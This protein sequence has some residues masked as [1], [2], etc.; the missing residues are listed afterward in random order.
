M[1]ADVAVGGAVKG[2]LLLSQPAAADL[3]FALRA[4]AIGVS[5]GFCDDRDPCGVSFPG[6][7]EVPGGSWSVAFAVS[8]DVGRC[9]ASSGVVRLRAT[10]TDGI[11]LVSNPIRLRALARL[12]LGEDLGLIRG[13][14]YED[15]KHRQPAVALNGPGYTLTGPCQ[16]GRPPGAPQ[17]RGVCSLWQL[18]ACKPP[19]HDWDGCFKVPA[20]LTGPVYAVTVTYGLCY[21]VDCR[22]LVPTQK[23]VGYYEI[24]TCQ[25]TNANATFTVPS[26]T[27]A[28]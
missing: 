11:E 23:V 20:T 7:I 2:L 16:P 10:G 24:L 15:K 6:E 13:D 5:T 22:A 26:C 8:F 28:V 21:E 3:L 12:E 25:R 27:D 17:A 14:E 1:Q 4:E 9:G 19:Q 18:Y